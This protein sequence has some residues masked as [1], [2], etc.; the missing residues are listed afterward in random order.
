MLHVAVKALLLDIWEGKRVKAGSCVKRTKSVHVWLGIWVLDI[1]F[2]VE[3]VAE[4]VLTVMLLL[5]GKHSSAVR[6]QDA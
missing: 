6:F 5:N 3:S 1:G 4:E 2:D